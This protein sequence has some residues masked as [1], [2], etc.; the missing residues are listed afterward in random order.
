[1]CAS[2]M[3]DSRIK[4]HLARLGITKLP[5]DLDL[6]T[7]LIEVLPHLP[8]LVVRESDGQTVCDQME[9]SFLS[10]AEELLRDVRY[11][12]FNARLDS[13]AVKVTWKGALTGGP[14]SGRCVIPISEFHEPSYW[15][16]LAGNMLRF[17][18]AEEPMLAAG[19]WKRW[20]NPKDGAEILSFA[21]I[22]H[23]AYPIVD[24]H[25]HD[26]SPVFLDEQASR[27]RICPSADAD[28][29]LLARFL[30]QRRFAPKL[31]VSVQ[32]ALKA[33]WEKRIPD[34]YKKRA[35]ALS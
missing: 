18:T 22:V 34:K 10:K 15:G 33:G 24:E 13:I 9:F 26:R 12:T 20:K 31:E 32:R 2:A 14:S 1:M 11:A 3:Q 27:E 23:D 35:A 17:S 4:K 8:G 19:L 7:F 25:G 28:P 16:P 5:K 29:S 21:I 30:E 6:E